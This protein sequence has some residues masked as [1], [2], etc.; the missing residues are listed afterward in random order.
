[1]SKQYGVLSA[2]ISVTRD[3]GSRIACS[4]LNTL[5]RSADAG[6]PPQHATAEVL[7]LWG[8]LG[9][10]WG[11]VVCKRDIFIL[12]EIWTQDKIYIYV[13]RHF[14]WLKYCTY[15][16]VS[17]LAPNYKQHILSPAK[18]RFLSLSQH[19]D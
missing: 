2:H 15:H 8:V 16:S 17:I 5:F 13:S 4:V 7:K 19:P 10:L 11:R 12:N 18:V 1:V 3:E 9:P 6:R 14:S